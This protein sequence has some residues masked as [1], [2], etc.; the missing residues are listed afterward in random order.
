[1]SASTPIKVCIAWLARAQAGA[2]RRA[3]GEWRPSRAIF[4]ARAVVAERAAVSRSSRVSRSC[5]SESAPG[6]V[7]RYAFSAFRNRSGLAK[8]S[9][10][11]S[12]DPER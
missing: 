7:L 10:R 9:S 3:F 2:N 11:T 8:S 12:G 5:S 4:R 1:M 6:R